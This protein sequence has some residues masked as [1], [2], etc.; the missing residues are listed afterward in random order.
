MVKRQLSP[1]PVAGGVLALA[2]TR[3]TKVVVQR[4]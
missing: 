4:G 2:M 1:L 3:R